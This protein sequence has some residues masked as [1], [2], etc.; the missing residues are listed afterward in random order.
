MA[1][2]R[3]RGRDRYRRAG[4]GAIA[5]G[6]SRLL[7][8][9]VLFWCTGV[10]EHRIGQQQAGLWLLLVTGTALLGFADLGIGNG[11]LNVIS[12]ALGRDDRTQVAQA[13]SSAFFAL[14]G[15]CA[16]VG[17]VAAL[18]IP[19][20]NWAS[21]LNVGPDA[22][23][24][25]SGAMTIFVGS[26]LISV[27][28][29]L[30]QRIDLAHQE[31]W[32]AAG[33]TALGSLVS[34]VAV[35]AVSASGGGLQ[36]LLLAMLAGPPAGYL[37]ECVVLFGRRRPELRPHP[38]RSTWVLG[39]RI[40]RSGALFFV[41]S[42]TTAL[43]YESD[44]FVI[45]HFLG[46]AAVPAYALPL[47]LFLMAPAAVAIV[48]MPL[49]PAYGEALARGD[50]PWAIRTLQRSVAGATLLTLPASVLLIVAGP[51]LL[52]LFSQGVSR[53]SVA[54]LAGMA[55]WAVTSAVSIALAMFF[56][57]ADAVRFQVVIAVLMAVAN[58]GS[59]IVLVQHI[60]LAGPVWG[61]AGS[62]IA[63]VL[64]PELLVLRHLSR[65]G[66]IPRWVLPDGPPTE[67]ST[68]PR[69]GLVPVAVTTAPSQGS[70]DP[71]GVGVPT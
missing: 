10:V 49:W 70:A 44:G 31:G 1:G 61:S 64:V 21:V 4:L 26:V 6:A 36:Q 65:T 58:L 23:G 69:P 57:G 35:L 37:V 7:A 33:A 60:G 59:S 50:L 2:G 51:P 67:P 54:L 12:Q 25:A 27:P 66:R 55:V 47:R 18:V 29:G 39:R 41:L 56:N 17:V 40:A 62:Q 24:Q 14:L 5:G 68:P 30:G 43:A 42:L 34:L 46:S 53:P 38:R 52:R 8:L 45:S 9:V 3:D 48:A 15:V 63:I 32:L 28:L 16:A 19:A 22:A 71:S 20:V 13:T 11:L